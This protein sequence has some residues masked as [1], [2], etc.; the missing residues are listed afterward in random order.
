MHVMRD[1]GGA[2]RICLR[3]SRADLTFQNVGMI[4][5]MIAVDG[6]ENLGGGKDLYMPGRE[7]F[8]RARGDYY[9]RAER[10][11]ALRAR[12]Q[13]R[14]SGREVV[15]LVLVLVLWARRRRPPSRR[16][17]LRCRRAP[18]CQ[19]ATRCAPSAQPRRPGLGALS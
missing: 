14:D 18:S 6:V 12:E 17:G 10:G 4:R 13:G 16:A 5:G 1:E 3:P 8:V 11:L 9:E 15:V 19:P 2:A 7:V